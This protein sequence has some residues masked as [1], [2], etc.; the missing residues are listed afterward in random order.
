MADTAQSHR[1]A[2]DALNAE[3]TTLR[4]KVNHTALGR[5]F[6]FAG[7]R[8]EIREEIEW[9]QEQIDKLDGGF[10]IETQCF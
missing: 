1:D 3:L 6:D 5:T 9:H 8:K 10:E 4:G 7:R 2:I